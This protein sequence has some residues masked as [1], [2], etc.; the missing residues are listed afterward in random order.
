MKKIVFA[1]TAFFITILLEAQ[2][3]PKPMPDQIFFQEL[4]RLKLMKQEQKRLNMACDLTR[5]NSLF[6]M[7][8]KQIA[9][10]FADDYFRLEFLQTAYPVIYDKENIYDLYDSFSSFSAV[11]RFH[12]YMEGQTRR[13]NRPGKYRDSYGKDYYFPEYNY[14]SYENYNE[15]SLCDRPMSE[16]EFE[17]VVIEIMKYR[18][19]ETRIQVAI[20]LAENNCLAVSQIM[21]LG[22]IIEKEQ[23]RLEYLKRSYDYTFDVDN[24]SY[25]NQL[26]KDKIYITEFDNFVRER[27]GRPGR[28][29]RTGRPGSGYCRISEAEMNE[30]AVNIKQQSFDNT[31]METAK[32]IVKAKQ[33]FTVFQI[34]QLI[35]IFTFEN[36]RLELAKFCYGYCTD[37]SDYYKLN[38]SFSFSRSVDD[39]NRFINEQRNTP[40]SGSGRN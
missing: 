1:V 33:C 19:D 23:K 25:G 5:R 31:R 2:P 29:S 13:T 6:T 34:K 16:E 14:P 38:N 3:L 22:S 7:Q 15:Y 28:D 8:A 35:E 21:K 40:H 12:D 20:R 18:D 37:Q 32:Q 30:I 11:M 26:F 10:L 36:S 24:Y 39:L 9:R 27:K 4:N 17:D